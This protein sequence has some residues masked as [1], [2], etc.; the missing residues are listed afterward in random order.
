MVIYPSIDNNDESIIIN[1]N[2]DCGNSIIEFSI[3]LKG[4]TDEYNEYIGI[5]FRYIKIN[6]IEE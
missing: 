2:F 5:V 3:G 6:N 1:K 4:F